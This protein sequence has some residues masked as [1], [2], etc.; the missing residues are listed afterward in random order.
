MWGPMVVPTR[1]YR[2]HTIIVC[3]AVICRKEN[4]HKDVCHGHNGCSLSY[5]YMGSTAQGPPGVR[6]A[7]AAGEASVIIAVYTVVPMV[8]G[9]A[10]RT[11]G[12]EGEGKWLSEW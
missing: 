6:A 4:R 8:G 3:A 1:I 5:F 10:V 11:G 7:R 12:G 2:E 9:C